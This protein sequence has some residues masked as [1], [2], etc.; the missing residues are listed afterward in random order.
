MS[1]N[2]DEFRRLVITFRTTLSMLLVGPSLTSTRVID[3]TNNAMKTEVIDPI[4]A[5]W[6]N[7]P[8][9][10][11][12]F[13]SPDLFGSRPFYTARNPAA[14]ALAATLATAA[15]AATTTLAATLAAAALAAALAAAALAAAL[16]A[17][18]AALAALS[19]APAVNFNRFLRRALFYLQHLCSSFLRSLDYYRP[20]TQ[21]FEH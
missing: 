1:F 18:F 13:E 20:H 5:S 6:F 21:L 19:T 7:E 17:I 9:L 10:I 3:V 16:A 15:L 4:D 14:A 12:S 2:I 11:Q 8:I